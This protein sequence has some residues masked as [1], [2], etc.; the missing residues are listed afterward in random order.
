[1]PLSFWEKE[2]D[3]EEGQG[4]NTDIQPPE[5]S[6]SNVNGHRSR[7]NGTN[8]ERAHVD[9]P[10]KGVPLATIVKKEDVGNNG[11]LNRFSGTGTESIECT[12][13][14]EAAVGLRSCSPDAGCEIDELREKV[15][16]SSTKGSAD[17]DPE[18]IAEAEDKD[19]H[20]SE[21]YGL[22]EGAVK[23]F[24]VVLEHGSEGK[25][26]KTLGKGDHA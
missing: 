3:H 12:S 6:P 26:S 21:L 4:N 22:G 24:D 11:R 10:V 20:A 1:M 19:W 5:G 13:T 7:D 17:W 16:G 25:R 14:H 18:E 2:D 9:D 8:H 23:L 15:D